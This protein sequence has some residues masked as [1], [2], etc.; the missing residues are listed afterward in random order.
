MATPI[1]IKRSAVAGKK[2]TVDQL[3][4]G[5]LAV[6][7]YDG[8]VFLKQDTGGVGISTGVVEVGGNLDKL[9]VTGVSTFTG[10]I[11]ANGDLDVDG[12]TELDDL[13]VSGVST[14][15][16][17]ADFNG[18]VDIDGHT[19]LD[20]V[21]VTGV[22]TFTGAA[23]FNGSVDI[24]GHTELD[25]LNV[26][27]V[28]TASGLLDINAGGQANTFK[29]E[30]LTDNRVVI[31]GTGGELEDDANLT[32]NGLT[33]S[34]GVDLDVDGRTELDIT[35]IS[36][37]LN[38]SGVSTFAGAVDFNGSVDIDGHT[39]LDDLNVSGVSTFAGAVDFNGS[40][41]IDGHTELDD[42]NVSGVS[43]FAGAVDFNGSVD[44][45]GHTELDDLNVSGVSTFAGAVDFNGSVDI[46]GHIEVD[47]L[48]VSGVS[49][50]T[51]AADF[52]GNID[53]DGHTELDNVNISGV[54]TTGGLL[55]IDAGAQAN[56]LKVED[57]TDNRVVIVGTGG[58]LED[59]SN[60][61]FNGTQLSV[62]VNLDVDGHT[63]LDNV[64][65]SGVSTF[66][67]AA[68]FNGS[69]DVDGHTE[70]DNVNVS[71]VTTTSGLLDINAGGQANTFKVE[72]LTDNRVVIAG[73]GGELEDD[74]NLTFNGTQLSVGV[75]LDVDGHTELDNVNV[76]GIITTASL[77]ATGKL[78]TTGI[79][80]SI[81]NG[82][83]NTAYIEGPSEIWIDPSPAGAGTTSGS[84]RIRGDLYVDGTEFIVDVDKIELGDFNIGIASTV[85]TNSLLDGAGLGI[86]ATSIRK[87]ITWNNATSALMSSE[88]WNLAS[89]KHYEINGTDVLTSDTLGSGIVNSSLTSVG[90]LGA[91][92]VSGNVNVSG[93]ST[94]AGAADFNGN[95]DVDGHTELDNVNVSGVTTT[96]GLLD[97]NAGGQANTFKVEDLTDNRVVI[98]G[99]GGELEDDANLTFN[100]TQLSVGANLDVSGVSTF[101]GAADFNGNIDVDGHTELDNVNVSGVSTFVGAADFNGSVDIDGHTELDNVNVSGVSTFAGAADFNGSVDI[102]GHTELDNVNVT[103]VATFSAAVN[104]TD[105]I[106]GYKYTAAPN[107]STVTLAVTVAS[108]DSTHRYN[109]TGSGNAYVIDGIQAP[110]LTLTPGR[111]YR[112]TN[113]NTGSHPF[114]FYLEADK[115]TQYDTNV[116]FQ[117]TYTEITVT[118]ETPIVLHYQCTAHAYMGNAVQTNANVVNTN[119]PATIRSTLNVTGVSTFTGAADFNGNIDVDGHTELDNLNV[120]GI[121]TTGGLLD[122]NAGGQA[123]TFKVEDLTDNRVVIAGTGGELED[124]ANLTFNGTQLSVGVNLDVDGLT[125]LDITN[126]SET[127]NVSGVST[128]AGA[129]DFNGSVDV[130]GHT[131]LDNVNVS[132]VSTFAGAADF[133]GSVDI[134]GH[135]ELDNVNVS[136]VSTFV[137]AADFNGN[138]D[139]DG[140][141]ELDDLNVSGVSTFVGA[142]DFNGNIDVDGHT[143]LDDLNVSGVTTASGLLDINAGGQANT[144]KVEDLT[145]NRI[146]IAGTGGELEDDANLTFNGTQLSVGV[147]LDV[148]GHTELD[149]VNVSGI[150]T[151]ASLN[152][153]GKLTTT[154][155]GISIANGAGNTAYIE[156]PSEIWIDP[157]P[158]GAGVAGGSVRIR[159]DLFVDGTTTSVNTGNVDFGQ[160]V[161][162]IASTVPTNVLL[163]G[164]G[165][166]IG[167]IGIRKF[168]RYNNASDT[169]QSSIGFS[170]PDGDAFKTGTTTVLNKTTLGTTVVNSSLTSVGALG[171]LNVTGIVTATSAIIG[172]GVTI[173]S[174]GLNV[175]GVVTATT[176]SGDLPTTNLTGTIT[177][178]QLA[179]SIANAKLANDSVSY[180]G[181]SLDLGGTDATPAF[182][183]SDATAYPY[184]S[185]TGITT[186]IVGDTTPQLGGNLDLNSKFITGTGGV[187]VTGVVTATTFVGA[188]TG[189]ASNASGATGDFSIADKII[190]TD[191]TNTAIRFPAADTFTVETSGSERL[192]I[193]SSGQIGIG[194]ANYGTAGQVLTSGGSSAAPS[195]QD[196]SGGGDGG[197]GK[198]DTG[199]TTSIYVSVTGGIGTASV[200]A[201]NDI[202]TGPGIAYTFPSTAGKSYII[203]SISVTN[204][205]NTNLY[206][207]SRHDFNGGQ[208]TPTAQRVVIPYQ[209]ALEVLEEPIIAKPSDT[210][211]FQAFAGTGT[212]ATGVNNGLDSF[213]TYSEK[214]DANFVGIGTTVTTASGTELFTST[215]NSSVIQSIRLCNYSL[216]M[217]TDASV[218]IYRGGTVGSIPTTGVRQGYLVYNL[219]VPKNSVIEILE[220]PKY[221]PPNDTI[222]VGMNGE[223]ISATLSGKYIT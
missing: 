123:N 207:S 113:D 192:R 32:F 215:T 132:G 126:I 185:L 151:T 70:L 103:G 149:D 131:E 97:I 47:N 117:N 171:E 57:L 72:D 50:F 195:W 159:G 53:V 205:Y 187:N 112:F 22:S 208:N 222:V 190:H 8:K 99:T 29:V 221:L 44:I 158:P 77:N 135:T 206:F 7:F 86:G 49:T 63:E 160:F 9:E 122:I 201:N 153:T 95:I 172:A 21:N 134:D 140:H 6:N 199:I 39:E 78:I 36:E 179:G 197:S 55:N 200:A 168:I 100:G 223:S 128:F 137:G 87:F 111:T 23:D 129:A 84:V 202:F 18:S 121:T 174:S 150:I 58:E 73:T 204:I 68:D 13:N 101:A 212:L 14:F 28:T 211:R 19:E 125:E 80:I 66:A 209:G 196:A 178:A 213:I 40:V 34:V 27:G 94:F 4:L 173:N 48:N 59:D 114:R 104:A 136:G 164:A 139:V 127:L 156:G 193:A 71:G 141:T 46:D 216:N 42:L 52:N 144:F 12:H 218:S 108:K 61:T 75:N 163:D 33:L 162:G 96:S 219:T 26:S 64:N 146:V 217:D 31:A 5:E 130:D 93:V 145:D 98:T 25:D 118:D 124:D 188:L 20:N 60:L 147:N 15:A 119:Y 45:D 76:S 198:F 65:V 133:N 182:N 17:A 189:T 138:I 194:G 143:E 155:I 176:F 82:A 170:V 43:T 62:G 148:D 79:G 88:N 214:D 115:T 35:N 10:A 107:G 91:L 1:R 11:D 161:V 166:G 220:R 175:T 210:L 41:D 120:S 16:G 24:D 51:G 142:A 54:T 83:G 186:E 105:I 85:S 152:A 106:K 3:Q 92:T 37:T 177:N 89:G 116:N 81:A 167:S 67:G 109:G 191:D 184:T 169:L 38:V 102:D 110:F 2:P 74:S 90:A 183:L 30:D 56:T 157:A 203:E 180:G 165:I 181:V 69:V 154:G